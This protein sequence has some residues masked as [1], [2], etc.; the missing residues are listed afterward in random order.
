MNSGPYLSMG[1]EVVHLCSNPIWL[2]VSGQEDGTLISRCL[3]ELD[4]NRLQLTY[5]IDVEETDRSCTVGTLYTGQPI[6]DLQVTYI[7]MTFLKE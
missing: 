4:G 7:Y 1:G 6:H 2:S 3:A 5:C